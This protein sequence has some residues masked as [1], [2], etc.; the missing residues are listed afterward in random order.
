MLDSAVHGWCCYDIA[1]EREYGCLVA[2]WSGCVGALVDLS[3]RGFGASCLQLV[4]PGWDS[5]LLPW[6]LHL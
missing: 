3:V 2:L 4:H 5:D 6:L 1:V